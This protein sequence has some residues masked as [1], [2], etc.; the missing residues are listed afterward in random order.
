MAADGTYELE[1]VFLTERKGPL[2]QFRARK[3]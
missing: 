2:V 3:A 1:D